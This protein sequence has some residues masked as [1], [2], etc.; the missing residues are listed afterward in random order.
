MTVNNKRALSFV[1]LSLFIGSIV[2]TA[3][4]DLVAFF[5][6]DGVVKDFFIAS[7]TIGWGESDGNW[8]NLYFLKFR[9]YE[10][11]NHY[12]INSNMFNHHL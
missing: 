8:I 11:D 12:N 3:L 7:K 1:L 2:A 9:Y 10:F 4:S 6:P 5:L